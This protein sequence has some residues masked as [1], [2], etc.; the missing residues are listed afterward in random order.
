MI[1][2]E[3]SKPSVNTSNIYCSFRSSKAYL[4]ALVADYLRDKQNG[5]TRPLKILDAACHSLITRSIFPN[6]S[7]YFGIDIAS[8]RL[9]KSKQNM[10]SGDTLYLG[11]ITKPLVSLCSCFDVVVSQNTF[12]H[13]PSMSRDSALHNLVNCISPGGSLVLSLTID[14][15]LHTYYQYLAT[16][17]S[18]VDSVYFDSYKSMSDE[19]SQ[20][21][22]S[23]NIVNKIFENE[24]SIPNNALYHR[25][26]C[27]FAH[28]ISSKSSACQPP[29]PSVNGKI[30]QVNSIPSLS[31]QIFNDDSDLLDKCTNQKMFDICI[32]SPLLYSDSRSSAL[33]QSL[34]GAGLHVISLS[35]DLDHLQSNSHVLLLGFE[36]Q[37]SPDDCDD[38]LYINRIRSN[39]SLSF[40]F[41]LV[42]S[43]FSASCTPSLLSQDY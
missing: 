23:E 1:S 3:S 32:C 28:D 6:S 25:Q 31:C 35:S 18:S 41:A 20:L 15:K 10:H 34:R 36:S 8:S 39:T 37:W 33:L 30:L 26:V 9:I 24:S 4:W 40:L 5:S 2:R 38:R 7:L 19:S 29:I 42:K 12:S 22:N 17:F 11:D 13:I 21:V 14:D 16:R 27:L 43:R